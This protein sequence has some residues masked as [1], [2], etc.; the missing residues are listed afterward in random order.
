VSLAAV[1][2][3]PLVVAT[4]G[5]VPRHHTEVLLQRHGL[6]LPT[7]CV[8]TLEV[9]VARALVR[10]SDA[11]WFTPERTPQVDLDDGVLV[12]LD[13]PAPGTAEPVGLLR[14]SVAEPVPPADELAAVLR[15]LAAG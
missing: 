10:R 13:V 12:R 5:T 14:R 6:R 15:E 2:E 8:E 3:H 9:A 11:V 4:A 7:G 1:L